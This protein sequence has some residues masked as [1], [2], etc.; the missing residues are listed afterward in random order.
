MGS[1]YLNRVWLCIITDKHKNYKCSCSLHMILR[2]THRYKAIALIK[3]QRI[4]TFK[5]EDFLC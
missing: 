5:G 1:Y 2:Q 4:N 3:N